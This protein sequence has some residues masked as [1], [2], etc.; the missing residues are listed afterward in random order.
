[1]VAVYT[2][3][4]QLVATFVHTYKNN[5]LTIDKNYI[6]VSMFV[7]VTVAMYGILLC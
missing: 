6:F 4:S 2:R 3:L 7:I 5:K 1:M